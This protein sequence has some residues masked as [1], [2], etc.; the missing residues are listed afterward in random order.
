MWTMIFTGVADR[1]GLKF[2]PEPAKTRQ[3]PPRPRGT[4]RSFLQ[5]PPKHDRTR[6][7][8]NEA[9]NSPQNPPNYDKTRHGPV[10]APEFSPEPARIRQNP[11]RSLGLVVSVRQG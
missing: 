7:R 6:H 11:P 10:D 8:S 2:F 3:N 5:N 9:P 1:E 4:R